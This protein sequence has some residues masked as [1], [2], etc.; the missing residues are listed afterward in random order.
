VSAYARSKP[1][2]MADSVPLPVPRRAANDETF[3]GRADPAELLRADSAFA[4]MSVSQGGKAAF[5]AF[6]SEAAVAFGG[7]GG[8]Q[9]SEGREALPA[10]V[11]AFS[12]GAAQE[13]R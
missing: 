10:A 2:P 12:A 8:A 9:M 4:A 1:V 3:G 6:A 13:R 11:D 7:G 5:L